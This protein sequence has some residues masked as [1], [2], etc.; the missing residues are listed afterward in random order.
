MSAKVI[1]VGIYGGP[2]SGQTRLFSRLS[3]KDR[4]YDKEIESTTYISSYMVST[5]K[6]EVNQFNRY[7][8]SSLLSHVLN[9]TEQL[10]Y[11]LYDYPRTPEHKA[12]KFE[13]QYTNIDVLVYCVNLS[14]L[15]NNKQHIIEDLQLFSQSKPNCPILVVA[16]HSDLV[17]D[18]EL[19][20]D[21]I[22]STIKFDIYEIDD[23]DRDYE[24]LLNDIELLVASVATDQHISILSS[25][26]DEDYRK[27]RSE[28]LNIVY[29]SALY[30]SEKKFIA[31]QLLALESKMQQAPLSLERANS[32]IYEFI[33][34]CERHLSQSSTFP[35]QIM[36]EIMLFATAIAITMIAAALLGVGVGFALSPLAGGIIGGLI[37]GV[38]CLAIAGTKVSVDAVR[39]FKHEYAQPKKMLE[40]FEKNIITTPTVNRVYK[41]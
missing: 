34:K 22:P 10:N 25:E 41:P 30:A 3:K 5:I 31:E 32:L 38:G 6:R 27:I 39:F 18:K 8:K 14:T 17:E 36:K 24:W 1:H 35:P 15:E 40:E 7:D 2:K 28:F 37:L 21:I 20:E 4:K 29:K 19:L 13:N 16:T 9:K 26:K 23:T 11:Q 12:Y 33:K